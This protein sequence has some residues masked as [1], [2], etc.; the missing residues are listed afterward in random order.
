VST[1]RTELP[2]LEVANRDELRAW[3]AENSMKSP[4]V[5]LAIGKK[6]N[7]ITELS[8]DD[9]VEE[10]LCFGWI[11]SVAGRLDEAR[12]TTRFTPRKPGGTWARTNKV[13]IERL[14]AEGLMTPAGMAVI[15]AAKADGSWTLLDDVED[16]IVPDDLAAALAENPAAN[17]YWR[18]QAGA[19]V[20]KIA[21]HRIASAKRPETR[22]K[23]IA[24]TVAEAARGEMRY[25]P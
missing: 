16:L 23:R 1:G 15:E 24:E 11:D 10:G 20:R 14:I 5:R 2:L 9:A 22:A 13:R 8:Y 7:T 4:G 25:S 18:T 21:L 12:F 6:G 17:Q 19:S 3:L